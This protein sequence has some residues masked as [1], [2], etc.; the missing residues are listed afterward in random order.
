MAGHLPKALAG[1]ALVSVLLAQRNEAAA[2]SRAPAE[3]AVAPVAGTA[4]G[5]LFSAVFTGRRCP[6][7]RLHV[8]VLGGRVGRRWGRRNRVFL[9]SRRGGGGSVRV[10]TK[11]EAAWVPLAATS[12]LQRTRRGNCRC[13]S[14]GVRRLDEKAKQTN[15]LAAPGT[16]GLV[17]RSLLPRRTAVP[18]EQRGPREGKEGR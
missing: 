2:D 11:N 18:E 6:S 3:A 8:V 10:T 16:E 7:S 14:C 5:A 17:G 1:V 15:D 4:Y 13:W 9:G 12:K